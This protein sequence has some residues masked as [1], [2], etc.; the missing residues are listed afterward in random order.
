MELGITGLPLTGK[1]TLFNALTGESVETGGFSSGQDTHLAAVKVPDARLDHLRDMYQP[2][3]C[4]PARV[5]CVDVAGLAKGGK[6]GSRASLLSALRT[7]D[8][9]IHVVRAFESDTV[10]VPEGGINPAS[11]IED[12]NLEL[13]LSDL[14]TVERRIERLQKEAKTGKSAGEHELE[15]MQRCHAALSAGTPLRVLEFSDEE[16]LLIKGYQFLT[17]KPTIIVVNIGEDHIGHEDRIKAE[18]AEFE[19][20]PQTE[21][22]V[23]SAEIEMEIAQLDEEDQPAFLEELGI[24]EMAVKRLVRT[25]YHLLDLISFF[26]VTGDEVRAWTLCRGASA[27][28]AAGEI[29]SDLA[30]GFIRAET[31][32]YADLAAA[33]SMSAAKEQGLTRLEGK[34]YVVQDGEVLTIRFSV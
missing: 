26:T 3:K 19:R 13:A 21:L 25:S 30:R 6:E 10:P 31:I 20:L 27:V 24:E 34:T 15:V 2:K 23:L 1:T 29:H 18:L 9:L 7:V 12:F 16:A 28:V 33:G 11:D 32:A 22:I 8:A 14:E 17:L 5:H 4:T